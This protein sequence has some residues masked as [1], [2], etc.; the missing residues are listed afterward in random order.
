MKAL[1]IMVRAS[2][3][4]NLQSQA[5]PTSPQIKP[6]FSVWCI[7]FQIFLCALTYVCIP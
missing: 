2:L 4:L 6:F 1:Q 3:G 7:S 5:L